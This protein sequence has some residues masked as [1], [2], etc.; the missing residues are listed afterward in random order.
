MQEFYSPTDKSIGMHD[1]ELIEHDLF[2]CL[3][4]WFVLFHLYIC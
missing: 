2:S 1:K 3:N 4:N